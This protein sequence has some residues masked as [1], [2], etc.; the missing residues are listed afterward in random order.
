MSAKYV[1]VASSWRCPAHPVV[2]AAIRDAGIDCYDFR[3][4]GPGK[5]GFAWQSV[6]PSFSIEKQEVD[7]RE[8]IRGLDHP[9]SVEGFHNDLDAMTRADTG[10]LVLPCGRS[11]HD[12][13]GW[14][15]GMGKRTAVLLDGPIVTPELMYK[16]HDAVL[17]DVAQ[18]L[19]WLAAS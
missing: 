4:P 18:L 10:V 14:M 13:I 6:M 5:T 7:A 8:Y 3:N 16:L 19:S 12:E 1:Y 15:A 9:L 2:V 11:A 17:P